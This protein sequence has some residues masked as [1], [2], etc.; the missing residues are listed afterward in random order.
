MWRLLIRDAVSTKTNARMLRRFM[1]LGCRQPARLLETSSD[2]YTHEPATEQVGHAAFC[3]IRL[4]RANDPTGPD[5]GPAP[6]DL[7]LSKVSQGVGSY[8][9]KHMAST[10]S[11][12]IN[13]DRCCRHRNVGCLPL[14]LCQN[15][16]YGAS[17]AA[18]Q[19]TCHAAGEAEANSVSTYMVGASEVSAQTMHMSVDACT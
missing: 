10:G 15:L 17:V 16:H 13:K 9:A 8:R 2:V 3:Q 6:S 4:L 12:A 11:T 1:A 7:K 5:Y 18:K 19:F 14:L